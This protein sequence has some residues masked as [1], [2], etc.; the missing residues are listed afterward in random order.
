MKNERA[1]RFVPRIIAH[2]EHVRCTSIGQIV[3]VEERARIICL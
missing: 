1:L 2:G 3:L